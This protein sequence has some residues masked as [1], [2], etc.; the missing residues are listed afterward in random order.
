MRSLT[1]ENLRVAKRPPR[2]DCICKHVAAPMHLTQ[3]WREDRG[4]QM[5]LPWGRRRSGWEKNQLSWTSKLCATSLTAAAPRWPR[6]QNDT[7]SEQGTRCRL[8]S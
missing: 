5:S 6:S 8:E 3:G 1:Q 4:G 7:L 2:G